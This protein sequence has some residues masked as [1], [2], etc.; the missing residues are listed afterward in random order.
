[1][2]P[3][4]AYLTMIGL[5]TLALRMDRHMANTIKVVK[6]L[7]E[8]PE[9]FWVNYPGL[10]GHA[11]YNVA[12]KQ[13]DGK[14]FGGMVAFGLKDEAACW[15]FIDRLKLI[16]HL[17]NLGDCKTLV[18]HPYSSQYVSFDDPTRELL[19]ITSDMIRLS[20]GIEA[21]EDICADLDQAL[22]SLSE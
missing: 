4:H 12:R 7:K 13:F 1:M 22:S 5:D 14:G 10:E 15:K 18:I 20:V 21:S 6:Y 11:S 9:V 16:Y 2:A 19:S 8:R 3:L 17:A